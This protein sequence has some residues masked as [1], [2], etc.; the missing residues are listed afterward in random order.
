MPMII[1]DNID[2]KNKFEFYVKSNEI[3]EQCCDIQD[4]N[5]LELKKISIFSHVEK[6]TDLDQD[7]CRIILLYL[8][9]NNSDI[10]MIKFIIN[11]MIIYIQNLLNSN[12]MMF[13]IIKINNELI[14][15]YNI[16]MS[17]EYDA[18]VRKE[19]IGKPNLSLVVDNGK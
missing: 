14:I 6:W 11:L 2:S 12:M 13:K 9:T 18:I 16:Q 8:L 19:K 10:K 17:T 7:M 3:E 15:E 5:I 4:H 1:I